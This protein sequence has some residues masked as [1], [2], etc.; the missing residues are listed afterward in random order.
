M[1]ETPNPNQQKPS[2]VLL[3]FLILP[4]VMLFA[5]GA[6]ML[7]SMAQATQTIPTPRAV[8]P[9]PMPT[10]VALAD[11]PIL[12]FELT[13]L[14]GQTVSLSDYAGR[15]VFLNFW[16]TWC[17]PCKR[18]LPA[19]ESFVAEQPQD[20]AVVLAVNVEEDP[21]VV[22]NFLQEQGVS[23]LIVPMDTDAEVAES[24]GIFQL[25]AT[26]V[27]DETGYVRYPKYGEVTREELDVYVEVLREGNASQG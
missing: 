10:A 15:I 20:G 13:T 6:M 23:N 11:T 4:L 16:A 17:E 24:Y 19:F 2:P 18:E 9:P 21:E 7:G 1:T 26:F 25:P 12:D 14:D 27:I 8:T 5:A 22:R 3:V